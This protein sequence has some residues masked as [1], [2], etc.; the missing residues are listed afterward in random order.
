[1]RNKIFTAIAALSL[2]LGAQSAIAQGDRSQGK[3]FDFDSGDVMTEVVGPEFGKWVYFNVSPGFNDISLV[4]RQFLIVLNSVYDAIAPY[5]PTA[6]GVYTRFERRPESDPETKN[7]NINITT[8]YAV[9]STLMLTAPESARTWRRMMK[10]IGLDPDDRSMDTT[11]PVGLGNT[12]AV[13]VVAARRHDG[14][15][16]FGDSGGRKFNLLPFS[17]TTGYVPVN[18]AFELSDASRWQPAIVK[19][20]TGNYRVQRFV[21]PQKANTE[22]YGDFNPRDFRF[23]PPINSDPSNAAA[24]KAQVD[25]VLEVSANLSDEQKM[26]AEFFDNKVR[27]VL[28]V[29]PIKQNL[30]TMNFVI[31]DFLL[32]MAGFDAGIVT[33]QEKRRFDAVRPFSAIRHVYGG[34]SVRAWGGPGR[35][36][37]E[38]PA[39][40]WTSYIPLADHPEY[41]SASACT[42]QA[43]AQAMKRF[44]GT[45]DTGGWVVI[46]PKGSSRIEPGITPKEDVMF[47]IAT[48]SEF[49]RLCGQ[50][51]LWGGTH[52]QASIDESF[53]ECSILGDLTY[54]YFRT[55]L[56]GTAPERGPSMELPLDPRQDDR[57]GGG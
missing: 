52:F 16:Q 20:R 28:A 6:V 9:Y 12:A 4:F 15:N 23:E 14:F 32:S 21:T 26:I 7:R 53:K 24:Y 55:L 57:T 46:L 27:D 31:L 35:G 44:T 38:I 30:D 50:S 49:G 13:K 2:F 25:K 1:M 45:D 42:C 22:P 11:T 39:E 29:P 54:D 33:W 17:D 36:T 48:W 47:E 8:M 56:D 43:Q 40:E 51:R 19:S 18:T 10:G 37:V 41:P 5:H 34:Q 3:E